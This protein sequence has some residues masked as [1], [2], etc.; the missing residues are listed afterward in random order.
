M[1]KRFSEIEIRVIANSL[2]GKTFG[3]INY[4]KLKSFEYDKGT[5]G[6]IIENDGYDYNINSFSE[7]DFIDAGIE[8]KVTP[9]KINKNGTLSAKERLVLNI[10]NY[11]EEVNYDFYTSHFWYKNKKI[12][13]LW[14]LYEKNK[15][16]N[17]LKITNELLFEFPKED[18]KII[19]DDWNFI[20]NKIR[21]G[22][23]HEL[24]EADTM[25]LGACTKGVNS[26]SLRKQPFSNIMAKQRAF[27]LKTSYMTQLVRKY[28]GHEY[29]NESFLNSLSMEKY[30][31]NITKKY[32]GMSVEDLCIAFNIK[33]TPKNI[34]GILVSRMFGVKGKLANTDE[35]LK[36]N[37]VPRT[38]RVEE[39]GKVKE[40]FPL[41]AFKYNEFINQTWD[42]SKLKE[43]L[44]TTKFMFFAFKNVKGHY[45]FYKIKL[46]NMPK[47]DI[48]NH[49]KYIWLKTQECVVSG[50]IVKR[51]EKDGKRITNFPGISSDNICHVRPHARNINDTYPLPVRD[52]V[53]GLTEY[54][55]HC[56]WLNNKYIEHIL[57]D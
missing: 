13:I 48:E 21:N 2:I 15:E 18:L 6:H 27:C 44:E 10:I 43:V 1:S 49:A 19:E 12:E 5:F 28:I 46:W 38:I 31:E 16:K 40:S 7:P 39:N 11:M 55:K 14:Y 54:M 26:N 35:F 22:K 17:E 37:I 4:N 29:S 45:V 41:P 23:A 36:A 8:L 24:S 32:R 3:E 57:K 20:I 51:I 42:K 53:T 34:N 25:Y 33:S 56:F 30:V 52:K 47:H 50:K 9:Y